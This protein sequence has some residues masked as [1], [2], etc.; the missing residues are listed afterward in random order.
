MIELYLGF[1][2]KLS[3]HF[4]FLHS[5]VLSLKD[6]YNTFLLKQ[7]SNVFFSFVVISFL[8]M[9]SF[10]FFIGFFKSF[11]TNAPSFCFSYNSWFSSWRTNFLFAYELAISLKLCFMSLSSRWNYLLHFL[12][13][14]DNIW[15]WHLEYSNLT[16]S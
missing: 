8:A 9:P 11:S 4:L 3:V 7:L 6:C 16:F 13:L 5:H 2:S 15:T 14:Q 12:L 10:L 1:Y